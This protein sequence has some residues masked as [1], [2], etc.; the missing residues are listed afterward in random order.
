MPKPRAGFEM[1]VRKRATIAENGCSV[2]SNA[3]LA[4]SRYSWTQTEH[5]LKRSYRHMG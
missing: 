2:D 1:R 4:S 5:Q 3:W